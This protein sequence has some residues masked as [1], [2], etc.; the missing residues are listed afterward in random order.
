MY[1]SNFNARRH[2]KTDI[3]FKLTAEVV[4]ATTSVTVFL[5]SHDFFSANYD[6]LGLSVWK[7][8]INSG[9]ITSCVA[10]LIYRV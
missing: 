10:N 5:C 7:N 8:I 1:S 4:N 9:T 2:R 6:N 3:N